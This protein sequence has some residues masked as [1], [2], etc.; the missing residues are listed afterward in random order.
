GAHSASADA[1][2][3]WQVLQ[4]QLS[5]Y[6]DLP[7]TPKGLSAFI[8]EHRKAR[9]LDS[10]GWF[11]TRHGK[12]A[13]GRGKYQGRMIREVADSDPD[14]LEWML[15]TDLPKDTIAVIRSILPN[16]GK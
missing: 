13:F 10:G 3:C 4:G 11:E 16:F 6:P 7:A 5:M 14:Y 8:A 1:R 15:S 9:T 2:A 12:P